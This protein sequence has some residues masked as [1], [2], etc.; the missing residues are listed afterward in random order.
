MDL[1]ERHATLGASCGLLGRVRPQV[2]LVDLLEIRRAPGRRSLLRVL[3]RDLDEF[4]EALRH[5]ISFWRALISEFSTLRRAKNR[6]NGSNDDL[7][8]RPHAALEQVRV[9]LVAVNL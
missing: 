7:I 9:H 1:A 5:R 8:Y 6:K 3:L 2:V 4:Q